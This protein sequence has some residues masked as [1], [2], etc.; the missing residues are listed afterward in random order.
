MF[1]TNFQVM[2]YVD[3]V[4]KSV[5]FWEALDF[6]VIDKQELDG[7]LVVE[8]APSSDAQGHFV[9]YDREFIQRHSPEVATNS[10][11]IMFNAENIIDLYKKIT[12]L[13]VEVG[14]LIQM[15]EQMVFNFADPDGNY[16]AVSGK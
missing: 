5:A 10:A 4:P 11:S 3:D 15:E 12:A 14:E 1:T 2:I 7:T 9:L 16:Y 8:I 6:V 13:D